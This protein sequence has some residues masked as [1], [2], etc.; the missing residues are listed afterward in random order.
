LHAPKL[1]VVRQA[2]PYG[3]LIHFGDGLKVALNHSLVAFCAHIAALAAI[4]EGIRGSVEGRLHYGIS[5]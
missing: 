5:E 2:S 3:G 4:P 1:E